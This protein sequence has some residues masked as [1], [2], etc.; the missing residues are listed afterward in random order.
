[1]ARF[2][3]GFANTIEVTS[4]GFLITQ[5]FTLHTIRGQVDNFALVS[6]FGRNPDVDT[7]GFEDVWDGGGTWTPPTQ[8]RIHDI[9]STDVNDTSAGTGA[10]T[11]S[12]YGLSSGVLTS[13]T[14][15]LNGTSN[16]PTV[17][18][19]GM[20]YRMTVETAGS[21]GS[22]AGAI[23]AT[24]QTDATV[25]A[26]INVGNNQTLMAIYQVPTGKTGYI[27]RWY[28]DMNKSNATGAADL[29]MLIK[30][31]GKV[32]QTKRYNGLIASGTSGFDKSINFLTAAALSI[33]KIDT[34]VTA[35]NTDISA[36]FDFYL[37][38]E[39]V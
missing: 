35:N 19:Y 17:N 12:I 26:Q 36:G 38:D 22:N 3:P 28:G 8:D 1:M 37:V 31:D 15:T 27:F 10:R 23:T 5:D 6:K 18:S 2:G 25:T 9:V 7:G 29:R 33:I 4:E 13:E 30:P 16:V 21:G 14:I 11:V 34:E 24:A 20:I 32:Y 39:N